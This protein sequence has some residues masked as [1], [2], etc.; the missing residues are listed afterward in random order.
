MFGGRLWRDGEFLKLW[1]G[2][3]ISEIGSQVSLL[4]LPTVAILVLGATP[5]QVGLLAACENLAFPVLGLVA[6]G[7]VDGPRQ[8]AYC[9]RIQRTLDDAAVRRGFNHR[10][11]HRLLRRGV[12]VVLAGAHPARRPHRGQHQ[13]PGHRLDRP[14]GGTGAGWL[15]DPA[16]RSG[17]GGRRGRCIVSYLGGLAGLDTASRANSFTDRRIGPSRVLRRDVGRDPRR[18]RQSHDLENRRQ[19]VDLK[20][21]IEPL[22]RRLLDLC[23]SSPAPEPGHRRRRI[24]RR[25]RRWLVGRIH[26]CMDPTAHWAWAHAVRDDLVGSAVVDPGSPRPVRLCDP[27]PVCFDVCRQLCQPRLQHQSGEPSP[28]DSPRPPS[29]PYERNRAN[30]YLGYESDRRLYRRD[31][32]QHVWHRARSVCRHRRLAAGGLLD[33]SWTDPLAR[34]TGTCLTDGCSPKESRKRGACWT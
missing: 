18:V 4:A 14:D 20:P 19:Y 22:L 16:D 26:R 34:A 17:P 28:G 6:G 1:S 5:F 30:H 31:H 27:T 13:A 29:G 9:I 23:L 33:S 32:W 11:G 10:S 25:R 24:R 21:R 7:Y 15:P 2:Q 12:P 8:R 3:A